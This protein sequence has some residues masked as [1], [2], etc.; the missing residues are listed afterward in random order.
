[1][2]A[3]KLVE[4]MKANTGRMSEAVLRKV[5]ASDR[6][7]ELLVKVPVEEHKQNALDVYSDLTA[8]LSTGTEGNIEE[9]YVA[10]GERRAQ[11]GIPFSD[12]SWAICCQEAG[13]R[14]IL[15]KQL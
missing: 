4:H 13:N 10:L 11:Q 6:C 7:R 12:L 2:R 3:L 14:L 1:M 5:R 9:R 15:E 8:W